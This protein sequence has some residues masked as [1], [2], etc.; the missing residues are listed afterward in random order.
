MEVIQEIKNKRLELIEKL[1]HLLLLLKE[2]RI[3]N[4]GKGN[5]AIYLQE[6]L[7]MLVNKYE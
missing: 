2:D 1:E 6:L 7:E 5:L 3:S 4:Y